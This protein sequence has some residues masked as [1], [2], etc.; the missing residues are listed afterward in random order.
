MC[1][2]AR[3]S[4][5]QLVASAFVYLMSLVVF[6]RRSIVTSPRRRYL[7]AIVVGGFVALIMWLTPMT[8]LSDKLVVNAVFESGFYNKTRDATT[9]FHHFGDGDVKARLLAYFIIKFI[10]VILSL[11]LPMPCGIFLPLIAVGGCVTVV[12]VSSLH[13]SLALAHCVFLCS[14]PLSMCPRVR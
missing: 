2:C 9:L 14:H 8:R 11:T 10:A 5:W 6:I 1:G 3:R 12:P 13:D 4:A 7:Y